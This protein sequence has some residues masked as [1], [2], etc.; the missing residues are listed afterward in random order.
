M[1]VAVRTWLVLAVTALA[2]TG[3][4]GDPD[5][6]AVDGASFEQQDE[7][8]LHDDQPC[9][10]ELPTLPEDSGADAPAT[11]RLPLPDFDRAWVCTYEPE[12]AGPPG[13]VTRFARVRVGTPTQL[14][15]GQLAAFTDDL[16]DLGLRDDGEI[17]CTAD[18]G[19]QHLVTLA[20]GRDLTGVVVEDYGCGFVR[21]TDDPFVTAAG[22]ASGPGTVA[23]V[24][25]PPP[26]LFGDLGVLR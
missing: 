16:A 18:L 21:L 14:D 4:G 6:T 20:W 13:S 12:D 17:A 22:A 7:L 2:G 15:P 24:F 10:A 23:G 9:P 1:T 8:S 26:S 11:E 3:C 19:P 25:D 5:D